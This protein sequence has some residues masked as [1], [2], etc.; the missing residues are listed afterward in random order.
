MSELTTQAHDTTTTTAPTTSVLTLGWR[1]DRASHPAWW[2]SPSPRIRGQYAVDD[3]VTVS[4]ELAAAHTAIIAASGAGKSFLLGTLIEEILLRTKARCVVLDPNAD[5]R[6][7]HS[8]RQPSRWNEARYDS[9]T[10]AGWLPYDTYDEFVQ[11]WESVSTEVYFGPDD[12]GTVHE[13]TTSSGSK[14]KK[15]KLWWSDV[16]AGTLTDGLDTLAQAEVDHCHRYVRAIGKLMMDLSRVDFPR[17]QRM[18]LVSSAEHFFRLSKG[19]PT[20]LREA[21]KKELVPEGWVWNQD[22]E[23]LVDLA[24]DTSQYVTEPIARYYFGKA[25]SLADTGIIRKSPAPANSRPPPELRVLDLPSFPTADVRR[26]AISGLLAEVWRSARAE[27]SETMK[28]ALSDPQVLDERTPTF[29]VV[30]EAHNLMPVTTQGSA[31][32]AL[33]D[34]FR[35]IMAEGRKYGL[36]LIIATQRPDKVD[37]LILS[38]CENKALMR[39]STDG[40]KLSVESLGL[41]GYE[42]DVQNCLKFGKGRAMLAGQWSEKPQEFFVGA[43]R[44]VEGGSNLRA[45]HWAVPR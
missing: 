35:T 1:L 21:V 16:D 19:S 27:W 5:F 11:R 2:M 34:Q 8:V 14:Q 24:S 40:V 23:R 30:D 22:F 32:E 13:A 18:D 15:F 45:A 6:N 25:K 17:A 43:R 42:S 7:V 38:E 4:S 33:R 10:R 12:H 36:F 20:I 3:L 44:T 9:S 37:P 39:L 31:D 41:K 26:V 29:I 28:R